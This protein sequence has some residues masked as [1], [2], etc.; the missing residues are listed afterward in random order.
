MVVLNRDLVTSF[1]YS[2]ILCVI[3]FLMLFSLEYF[4]Y[5]QSFYVEPIGNLFLI[6]LL[7]VLKSTYT[8]LSSAFNVVCSAKSMLIVSLYSITSSA[9][10][11]CF[12]LLFY[13]R[14]VLADVIVCASFFWGLRM[15]IVYKLTADSLD[16][17]EH[18]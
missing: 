15:A 16:G 17:A 14:F 5:V 18:V 1:F 6:V 11:M 13:D 9:V 3:G 4:G 7:G 12:F 10:F 8:A 2:I